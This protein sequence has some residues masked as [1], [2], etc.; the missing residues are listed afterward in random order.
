MNSEKGLIDSWM[1][2]DVMGNLVAEDDVEGDNLIT[3]TGG[4][5]QAGLYYLYVN[6]EVGMQVVKIQ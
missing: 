4:D 6:G 5:L 2:Y 3:I 1:L